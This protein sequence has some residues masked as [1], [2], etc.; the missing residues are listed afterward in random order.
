[1]ARLSSDFKGV[2]SF[3]GNLETGIRAKNNKVKYLVLNGADDTF[4]PKEEIAA[5]KKET[6][7]GSDNALKSFAEK[8]LP[9]LEHHLMESEKTKASVK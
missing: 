7:A 3:H 9:T 6:S 2:V 8:T 4:V 1:M 5:F